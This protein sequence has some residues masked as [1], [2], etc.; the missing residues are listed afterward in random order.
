MDYN[1]DPS[2]SPFIGR[3]KTFLGVS[4]ALLVAVIFCV[5]GLFGL[6]TQDIAVAGMKN[7]KK[8]EPP[9]V[10]WP[11]VQ[12]DPLPKPTPPLD[13]RPLCD[14]ELDPAEPC[15]KRI[16][17][18]RELQQL[19]A[20]RTVEVVDAAL[21]LASQID[22]PPQQAEILEDVRGA[23]TTGDQRQRVLQFLDARVDAEVRLE[24]AQ[25]LSDLVSVSEV[26]AGLERAA[27][28]DA[29]PRVRDV[30]RLSLEAAGAAHGTNH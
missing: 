15:G 5:F 12:D 30:A 1:L 29:S 26:H 8:Y 13:A 27:E 4:L 2:L 6:R 7:R 3:K 11:K 21:K 25:T 14:I 9:P 20:G 19:D 18:L 28:M 22:C 24:A 16:E 10:V 23:V 17:A